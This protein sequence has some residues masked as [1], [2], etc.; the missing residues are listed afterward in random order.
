MRRC[1]PK[2][3]E[4][5]LVVDLDEVHISRAI[6]RDMAKL[7]P[8]NIPEDVRE[9]EHDR[10]VDAVSDCGP[11]LEVLGVC[12]RREGPIHMAE[13]VERDLLVGH[14][15]SVESIPHPLGNVLRTSSSKVAHPGH[16]CTTLNA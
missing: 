7:E 16:V 6:P 11:L 2:A 15:T 14:T 4:D 8:S 9:R 5:G 12:A 10:V 1:L 3:E 13:A